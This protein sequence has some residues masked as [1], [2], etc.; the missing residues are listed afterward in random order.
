M[1]FWLALAAFR[2][3]WFA[4]EK[5]NFLR[6]VSMAAG[7]PQAAFVRI[8]LEQG[9][10]GL[11]TTVILRGGGMSKVATMAALRSQYSPQPDLVKAVPRGHVGKNDLVALF[12]AIQDF[13]RVY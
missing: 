10:R 9:F 8:D 7:A 2:G 13:D 5:N 6:F 11:V 12:E 3:G 1:H 4:F